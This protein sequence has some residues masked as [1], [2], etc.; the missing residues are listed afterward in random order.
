MMS[1]R[2][3]F[4]VVPDHSSMNVE[5]KQTDVSQCDHSIIYANGNHSCATVIQSDH[6][7]QASCNPA[8]IPNPKLISYASTDEDVDELHSHYSEAIDHAREKFNTPLSTVDEA[9]TKHST[10]VDAITDL[11]GEPV[12]FEPEPSSIADN[13][14]DDSS[15]ELTNRNDLLTLSEDSLVNIEP[16]SSTNN[17]TTA[18]QLGTENS[19]LITEQDTYFSA[20]S[21]L[22]AEKDLYGG[23]ELESIT[24]DEEDTPRKD[25]PKELLITS[26]SSPSHAASPRSTVPPDFEFKLPSFGEW[27]NR[28][29]NTFLS[30]TDHNHVEPI[31]SSRSSSDISIHGSQSTINTSSSSQIITVVEKAH[32]VEDECLVA[33]E[34]QSPA[35]DEELEDEHSLNGKHAFQL[36]PQS[37]QSQAPLSP[38][39][40]PLMTAVNLAVFVHFRRLIASL[41]ALIWPPVK[42]CRSF[43]LSNKVIWRLRP[44]YCIRVSRTL[45][46][47]E[48]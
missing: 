32:E 42:F 43:R 28:A 25:A 23:Y 20:R 30:E 13:A 17:F 29:F 21:D 7:E 24:D 36:T 40:S 18:N 9:T 31:L 12:V 45:D 33:D 2:A 44:R 34:A 41:V 11:V 1:H 19:E 48:P 38:S 15:E 14:D 4:I 10:T 35:N 8:M 47:E 26:E 16:A 27:I 39:V 37:A 22:T 6:S 3:P 46:I 5:S